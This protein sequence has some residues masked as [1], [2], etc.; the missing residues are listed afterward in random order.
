MPYTTA[1]SACGRD[2]CRRKDCLIPEHY[3]QA[4]GK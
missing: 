2:N 3:H 1:R 4:E